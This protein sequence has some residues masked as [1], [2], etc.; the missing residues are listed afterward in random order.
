[1][2]E[3]ADVQHV[4]LAP[5]DRGV[6]VRATAVR[7]LRTVVAV[8][9]LVG[10]LLG[11]TV[12][13][14]MPDGITRSPLAWLAAGAAAAVLIALTAWAAALTASALRL[15]RNGAT[16]LG[17]ALVAWSVLDLAL[18]RAT[19]PLTHVGAVALAPIAS[20][21][22]LGVAV[23]LALVSV[24]LVRAGHVS[25]E[26][27]LHRARL[28]QSLRFAAT[29]QDLRAV[30]NLRHQLSHEGPR[31]RPW[32]RLPGARPTGR[33]TWRRDWHGALRWPAARITRIVTL[34][35]VTGA[36]AAAAWHGTTPFVALCAVASYAI[37][38]DTTEGFAQETD[39]PDIGLGLPEPLGPFMLR[40][41]V[42]PVAIIGIAGL[43]GTA[44]A[45]VTSASVGGHTPDGG[46][47]VTRVVAA[48]ALVT[49]PAAA[50][51]S[52][53]VGRPDRDL[54]VVMLHPG[55]GY[56]LQAAPLVI[57]ALAFVP[58]VAATAVEP[59]AAPAGVAFAVAWPGVG[60]AAGVV[61]Y[62]RT[63]VW[64]AR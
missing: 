14:R 53:Y 47:A 1:V 15:T 35:I 18:D 64:Q 38:L 37:A 4:L 52:M 41:L 30:I 45:V 34:A 39:H 54:G 50:A 28:V 9:V 63:R 19:S 25:L 13:D 36:G 61:A 2:F 58:I 16:L 10:S 32:L 46:P 20:V 8:G 60:V 27:A 33:A 59:P 51:L 56:A 3:A 11:V 48:A 29:F 22:P 31:A 7:Q 24:A 40:H 44:A 17:L 6:V 55:I 12:A 43:L 49:M 26:P 42:T 57:T 23:V 21:D 5:V 62:L